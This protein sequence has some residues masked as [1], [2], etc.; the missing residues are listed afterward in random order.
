MI[1]G[2]GAG[3][4]GYRNGLRGLPRG[5]GLP[6]FAHLVALSLLIGLSA[7]QAS[8]HGWLFFSFSHPSP[9]PFFSP[10]TLLLDPSLP[11]KEMTFTLPLFSKVTVGRE[12]F[13]SV[14]CSS[15]R[16][17]HAEAIIPNQLEQPAPGQPAFAGQFR[18]YYYAVYRQRC[19]GRE[20][21]LPTATKLRP[22]SLC[23]E[24]MPPP[25]LDLVATV[26]SKGA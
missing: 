23:Q 22:V 11:T 18:S 16:Q 25:N 5:P 1:L 2:T 19:Q 9:L 20:G 8:V 17:K 10:A 3:N 21:H 26:S 13:S 24:K 12:P 15:H 14:L 4:E 7:A 6:G